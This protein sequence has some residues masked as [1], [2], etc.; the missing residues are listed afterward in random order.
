MISRRNIVIEDHDQA[1]KT[2]SESYHQHRHDTESITM[3]MIERDLYQISVTLAI[4]CDK[5]Y[6]KEGGGV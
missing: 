1:Q 2:L 3:C 6:G 5:L 4:I